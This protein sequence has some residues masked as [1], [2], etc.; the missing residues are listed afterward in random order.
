MSHLAQRERRSL[1]D[2]LLRVGP[3]APTLCEGWTTADLAAH[4]V[5]RERRPDAGPGI[6]I[7]ALAGYTERVQRSVRDG[8]SWE[9]L[10]GAVR[11]GPP[12]PL[13]L[14]LVDEP[15]NTAEFFVH[16]ED[17]R[18]AEPGWAPRDLDPDLERALWSRVRLMSRLAR[19]A[20]PVGLTIVAPGYGQKE[21]RAAE[22]MV[23]MTGPPGELALFLFGRQ[24][25]ARVEL[26]G[27]EA[28]VEQVRRA[29]FGL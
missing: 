25:V 27:D 9:A 14:S 28:A 16:H 17:V 24:S 4:L 10:V 22:P 1:T 21:V 29:K 26:S 13:R 11:S 2:L 12:F 15:M 7:P 5:V 19:R 23:T 3:D 6:V 8:R 18:R 20:V